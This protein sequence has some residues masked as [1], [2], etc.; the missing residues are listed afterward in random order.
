MK[1]TSVTYKII[2]GRYEKELLS[3]LNCYENEV[4][5]YEYET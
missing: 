5:K 1:I 4:L 3:T 2:L